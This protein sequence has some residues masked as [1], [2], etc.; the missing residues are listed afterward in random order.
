[1]PLPRFF[2]AILFSLAGALFF[3]PPAY[4]A[5]KRFAPYGGQLVLATTSDP[6]TFNDIVARETSSTQITGLI[7]EGLTTVNAVDLRVEPLLARRW[8]VSADGL[9]W[10]FYLRRDVRWNDGIPFTAADVVFTFNELIYNPDIPSSAA[11]FFLIG[12]KPIRVEAVDRYTVR[13]TLP[14]R[15]APFLRS[16]SQPILPA[17]CLRS[18]VAQKKFNF[19]WG[20]DTPP[21]QIVGTG[22]FAL[23]AYRPGERVVLKRNPF[24][25]KVSLQGDRLPY[26]ERVIYVIVQN[27]DTEMLKFIDGELDEYGIRGADYPLLKPREKEK[28]FTIYEN[29]PASGSNFL[30]FNQNTGINPRTGKP[31]VAPYKSAWFTN[32][33]FRKAVAHAIDKKRIIE[34]LMN[35][36]GY[37]QDSAINVNEGVFYNPDVVKYPYDLRQAAALLKQAGFWDRNGDGVI[38][39]S[40]GH[41]VEFN[42]ATNAGAAERLQIAAIIRSDLERLGMRVN[43]KIVEFNALVNQLTASYDWDAVIMGLSGGGADPHF[44][45]NVWSSSGGLHMWYPRQKSPATAWE[46]RIDAIFQDAVQA[47]DESQRKKLY[48]EFQAIVADQVP[49]IYTVLE[50]KIYAVRDK[51]GNLKPANYGGAFHNIEEIYI[52]KP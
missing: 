29:G 15:F 23:A 33:N 51:F 25:W 2:S 46:A 31:F 45:V 39:D 41:P 38:E 49:L 17:H 16:M 5:A 48:D 26:L 24:Y 12:G 20:I 37:A 47:L 13:F 11:D 19:T 50:A 27:P 34:I 3:A 40:Q 43:F 14:N 7:F 9:I 32:L 1:M 18:A 52:R 42:L 36:L 21:E 22:P 35:G 10:T 28:K 6:K 44:S 30:L 8:E 4:A